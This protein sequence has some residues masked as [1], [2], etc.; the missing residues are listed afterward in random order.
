MPLSVG[1]KLGHYEVLSLL[2]QGGMGEVWK[3]REAEVL[4][5]LDHTNIGPIYGI[6]DSEDSRGLVLALIEGPTLANQ[7][8]LGPLPIDDARLVRAKSSRSE[9]T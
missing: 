5:S 3:T 4:A 6:I 2:G 1:E 9:S 7:I 8:A